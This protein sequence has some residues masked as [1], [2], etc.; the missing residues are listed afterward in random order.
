MPA[1]VAHTDRPRPSRRLIPARR[2]SAIDERI[3]PTCTPATSTSSLLAPAANPKP[4]QHPR[5]RV[6]RKPSS[7]RDL[8]QLTGAGQPQKVI[9]PAHRDAVDG[10]LWL[11]ATATNA[12]WKLA[13]RS[14]L[15]VDPVAL[16]DHLR[17]AT[18]GAGR[19]I[20]HRTRH[21]R[22]VSAGPLL[23]GMC[24]GDVHTRRSDPLRVPPGASGRAAGVAT[25][26]Q[27]TTVA[28][29]SPRAA[30]TRRRLNPAKAP[31]H[32]GYGWGRD[33]RGVPER[34]LG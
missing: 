21:P 25:S 19:S 22:R 24:P 33:L 4:L 13:Q 1:P 7:R 14:S 12:G 28:S 18:G 17:L 26:T 31:T 27:T 29:G 2:A 32:T 15:N 16:E 5:P 3:P 8:V 9:D 30:P 20:H 6:G 10:D 11:P 23:G 34:A